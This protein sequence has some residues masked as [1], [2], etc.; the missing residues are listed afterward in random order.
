MNLYISVPHSRFGP[1]L[2]AVIDSYRN[3]SH[4]RCMLPLCFKF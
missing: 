4:H 1:L 3:K 2:W